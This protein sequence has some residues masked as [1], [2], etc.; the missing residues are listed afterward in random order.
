MVQTNTEV[1]SNETSFGPDTKCIVKVPKPYYLENNNPRRMLLNRVAG[2]RLWNL[3]SWCTSVSCVII[4]KLFLNFCTK[5]AVVHNEEPF[6]RILLDPNRTRPILTDYMPCTTE[7]IMARA[8]FPFLRVDDPLLWGSLPMSVYKSLRTIRWTLGAQEI[9]FTNPALSY[10]FSLG[11][12]VPTVRG[13]GIHQPA[14]NYALDRLNDGE[15]VHIFPEGKVNQ[16]ASLIRF[17]WGI[18]RL[19]M[20]THNLPIV[21]PLWHKGLE[22]VMPEER[23]NPFIPLIGK[24]IK[25]LFGDPIDLKELLAELQEV[26]ETTTRIRITDIIFRAMDE[27]QRKACAIEVEESKTR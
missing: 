11:R 20:E 14:M 5:S 6:V 24:D 16:T 1:P 9:C 22:D 8:D 15:W 27:L 25:I 18:G 17:K 26:D 23:D 13:A 4:A 21:V 7:V 2:A 12:V 3:A 10:F 19:L